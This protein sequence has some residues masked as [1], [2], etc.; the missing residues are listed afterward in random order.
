MPRDPNCYGRAAISVLREPPDFRRAYLANTV[1][2][3]GESFQFV[4]VTRYA[5]VGL[6]A[7]FV[8]GGIVCAATGTGIRAGRRLGDEIGSRRR[9]RGSGHRPGHVP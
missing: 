4:A 6:P 7:M 8:A 2:G 1:S 5:V 3:L 9:R